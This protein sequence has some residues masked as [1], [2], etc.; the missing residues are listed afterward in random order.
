MAHQIEK[1]KD[2]EKHCRN[3]IEVVAG[4]GRCRVVWVQ[5]EVHV[6]ETKEDPVVCGVL[7]DVHERHRVI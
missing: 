6:E 1:L 4:P 2:A 7:K 5:E 3:D